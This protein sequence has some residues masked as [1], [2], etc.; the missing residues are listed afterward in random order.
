M[1]SWQMNSVSPSEAVGPHRNHHRRQC[2]EQTCMRLSAL[3]PS[4]PGSRLSVYKELSAATLDVYVYLPPPPFTDACTSYCIPLDTFISKYPLWHYNSVSAAVIEESC[5]L[6]VN[7]WGDMRRRAGFRQAQ[8]ENAGG[9][10]KSEH[11]FPTPRTNAWS[12]ICRTVHGAIHSLLSAM[13]FNI[14]PPFLRYRKFKHSFS[15]SRRVGEN[16]DEGQR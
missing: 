13:S 16:R 14:V 9:E 3:H 2:R 4:R 12:I 6:T 11:S 7:S 8:H 1:P 15:F 5:S 10:E